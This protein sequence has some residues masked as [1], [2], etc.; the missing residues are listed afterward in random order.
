MEGIC[1]NVVNPVHF[2]QFLKGRCHGVYLEQSA[3]QCD[4]SIYSV[5]LPPATEKLSVLSPPEHYTGLIELTSP[6]VV[7]EVIILFETL[8][9]NF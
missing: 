1:V 2:F 7:P 4:F 3:G 8:D 9:K 6:T 5:Y